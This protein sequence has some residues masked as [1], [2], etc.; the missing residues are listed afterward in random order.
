MII[1]Y[2]NVTLN[3]LLPFL[4][5]MK[6]KLTILFAFL[7]FS[8]SAYTG[9]ISKGVKGA[10]IYFV[11]TKAVQH[12][13]PLATRLAIKKVK[14]YLI[15]NPDKTSAV[16]GFMSGVA[17]ENAVI[18]EKMRS[19]IEAGDFMS[20]DEIHQLKE[21]T[22]QYQQA[23][24]YVESHVVNIDPN[25]LCEGF[26]VSRLASEDFSSYNSDQNIPVRLFDVGSFKSL[27]SGEVV[28]DGLEHDHIPSLA[29]I[30]K[31]ITQEMGVKRLP[32][33]NANIL[34]NNTTAVEVDSDTH[35]NGRT[36]F[37]KNVTLQST[38]DAKD[39]RVATLKDFAYHVMSVGY[40]SSLLSS[41]KRVYIRNATMC[42][43]KKRG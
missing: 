12:G 19:F 8:S 40:N 21:A 4:I 26:D 5:N 34:R 2:I 32:G 36:W 7:L 23:Y 29:A 18:G 17:I 38:L 22:A 28:N 37:Y 14:K 25:S 15:E 27:K 11:I 13:G 6:V 20:E 41:L 1:Y 31:Y 39:L 10:A 42:L 16:I 35:K 24:A 3:N 30:K 33:S 9:V 43:Y